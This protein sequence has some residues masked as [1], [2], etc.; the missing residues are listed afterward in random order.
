[1][2]PDPKIEWVETKEDS[3]RKGLKH[4]VVLEDE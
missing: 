2:Y 1:L 3:K 4:I